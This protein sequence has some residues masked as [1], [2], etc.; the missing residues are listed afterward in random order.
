MRTEMWPLPY[1]AEIEPPDGLKERR[2]FLL[3]RVGDLACP[4]L[5]RP[6]Q[7]LDISQVQTAGDFVAA[8]AAYRAV[9]Y[10]SSPWLSARG[11]PRA[12]ARSIPSSRS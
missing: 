4:P 2:S 3:H 9:R 7:C 1:A 5:K 11:R 6:L 12:V 8:A 10:G